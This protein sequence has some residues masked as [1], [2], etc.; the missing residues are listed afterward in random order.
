MEM[1]RGERLAR[2]ARAERTLAAIFLLMI[3]GLMVTGAFWA[4][5]NLPPWEVVVMGVALLVIGLPLVAFQR[6]A[7]G[8][9]LAGLGTLLLFSPLWLAIPNASV[10]NFS[11]WLPIVFR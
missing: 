7:Q 2:N 8:F 11:V 3:A 4:A 6:F 9:F 1:N 10:K 5:F